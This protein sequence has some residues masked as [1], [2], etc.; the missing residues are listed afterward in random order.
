[1]IVD[2]KKIKSYIF[3]NRAYYSSIEISYQLGLKQETVIGWIKKYNIPDKVF[4][5]GEKV[6]YKFKGSEV[7]AILVIIKKNILEKRNNE[8][9]PKQPCTR[10]GKLCIPTQGLCPFCQEDDD[11]EYNDR[12]RYYDMFGSSDG[13]W[14]LLTAIFSIGKNTIKQY[15]MMRDSN[16]QIDPDTIRLIKHDI[17]RAERSVMIDEKM[18]KIYLKFAK[19]QVPELFS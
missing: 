12:E 16:K 1:M 10:C 8:R 17:K 7:N 13:C 14:D 19:E 15:I 4:K 9:V 5:Y 11:I 2:G 6:I 3:K 18:S